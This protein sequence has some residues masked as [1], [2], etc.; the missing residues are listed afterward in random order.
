MRPIARRMAAT[1][2]AIGPLVWAC[3]LLFSDLHHRPEGRNAAQVAPAVL[4]APLQPDETVLI[5]LAPDTIPY[6]AVA[7]RVEAAA[8]AQM[9][10]RLCGRAECNEREVKIGS[11]EVVSLQIPADAAAGGALS[12]SAAALSGGPVSLR[13]DAVTPA[14]EVV[15]GYSWRL[16]SR[17]AR[18]VFRAMAG[19]DGFEVSLGACALALAAGFVASLVLALRTGVAP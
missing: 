2:L 16:P 12:L 18:K 13:G 10:L 8:P 11:G 19:I 5:P 15:Q 7:V 1:A 9:D 4:N 6:R 3:A 17:R 14:V